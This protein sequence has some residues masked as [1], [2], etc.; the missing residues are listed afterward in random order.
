MDRF[1]E[2][3]K[4]YEQI[5]NYFKPVYSWYD[6]INIFYTKPRKAPYILTAE[7]HPNYIDRTKP[8]ELISISISHCLY[9]QYNVIYGNLFIL[10]EK[11]KTRTYNDFN[12]RCKLIEKY[13]KSACKINRWDICV[14]RTIIHDHIIQ[15]KG[16]EYDFSTYGFK[17]SITEKN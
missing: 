9:S 3:L 7:F 10:Y 12:E 11:D 17:I 6:Y 2:M 16:I 15:H 1:D 13:F 5:R 8:D 14:D 4:M